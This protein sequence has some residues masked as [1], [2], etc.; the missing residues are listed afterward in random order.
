MLAVA[1]VLVAL[2]GTVQARQ[3]A[4]A[5]GP[6]DD[7]EL[8]PFEDPAPPAEDPAGTDA[9]Q[10]FD[11]WGFISDSLRG[12]DVA[13]NRHS[14]QVRAFLHLIAVSEGTAKAPDPYR[15]CYGYRHTIQDMTFH[16]AAWRPGA[17]G[18]QVREWSG[19][20]LSDAMCRGAGMSPGCVSTAAGRYQII[21]PTWDSIQ[22]ALDLP[23]FGPDSQDAAAVYLLQRRGAIEAIEAGELDRAIGLCRKEWA[24]LP[25]AGY[26]QPE[27]KRE[28]LAA[29]FESA[30]GVL[31]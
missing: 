28:A 7:G 26:G 8:I 24:S 27:Q 5:A 16:P 17:A 12:Y 25:G 3:A 20:R 19:E 2:A 15:V 31:A 1:V 4:Q 10:A 21:R 11:L 29:A 6:L 14:A 18:Q 9:G 23:D 13:R 22:R 30:G